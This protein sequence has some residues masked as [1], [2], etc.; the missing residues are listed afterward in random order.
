METIRLFVGG[1]KREAVGLHVFL[2]SVL[3]QCSLPVAVTVITE[4]FSARAGGQRDGS[5]AFTYARFRVP[6]MA[7]WTPALWMD[8]AD[9]LC[10]G[11][12]A[13]LWEHCRASTLWRTAALVAKH[14]YTTGA[15]RKYVGTPLEAANRAYPRKNWSSVIFW[16]SAHMTNRRTLTEDYV[17]ATDGAT[18]HRFAWIPDAELGSLPLEWNHLVGESPHNPE[19]KLVH[20]TLG[21]PGFAHYADCDYAAEWHAMRARSEAGLQVRSAPPIAAQVRSKAAA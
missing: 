8:G 2:E 14:D 17:R 11:D 20:F 9:M 13:E 1:D 7:D 21:I 3:D 19:A 12:L 18:L 6:A 10:R 15:A 16:N 4:A 5:N